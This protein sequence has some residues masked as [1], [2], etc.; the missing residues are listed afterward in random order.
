MAFADMNLMSKSMAD[1]NEKMKVR[2]QGAEAAAHLKQDLMQFKKLTCRSFRAVPK[3]KTHPPDPLFNQC[4][5]II[6]RTDS[7]NAP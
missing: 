1:L 3:M 4:A 7:C 6:D 2:I 5:F